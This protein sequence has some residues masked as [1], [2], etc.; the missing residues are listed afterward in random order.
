MRKVKRGLAAGGFCEEFKL[1]GFK[2]HRS[3]IEKVV[4]LVDGKTDQ[5]ELEL[6][7]SEALRNAFV[8]GNQ[9]NEELP[10]MVR[11]FQCKQSIILEVED[12]GQGL[13]ALGVTSEVSD[14]DLMAE[15]GR[16][17]FLIKCYVDE[18]EFRGNA[19]RMVKTLVGNRTNRGD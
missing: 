1:C 16:G 10:I 2:E 4:K 13:Q 8:H 14:D 6:I 19:V 18:L 9:S 15:S 7:L 17:L 12:C 11:F 3:T 5:F